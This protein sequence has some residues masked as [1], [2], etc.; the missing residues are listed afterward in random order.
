MGAGIM[1][2]FICHD[3]PFGEDYPGR[4]EGWAQEGPAR[5]G[6]SK[7]HRRQAVSFESL[8]QPLIL[9]PIP[10]HCLHSARFAASTGDTFMSSIRIPWQAR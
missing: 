10:S 7:Y 2:Q 5:T 3:N 1:D 8:V 6:R 4:V 9:R